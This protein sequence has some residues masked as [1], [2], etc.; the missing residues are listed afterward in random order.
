MSADTRRTRAG[1]TR[2]LLLRTAERLYAER[3][4]AAVSLRQ[5]V[6]AAGVGNNS[7]LAYHF[8]A[9]PDVVHAIGEV[10]APGIAAHAR[11]LVAA[12]RD[13]GD[14]REHVACLVLPYVRHLA[15][16]GVPSW[17]ARFTAQVA[18]DPSFG[19]GL[20]SHA[21]LA[22]VLEVASTRVWAHMPRLSPA[23]IT[24]RTSMLRQ[25]LIH[26][27]AQQEALAAAGTPVDWDRVGSALTD[28]ATGL[29]LASRA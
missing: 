4:L 13:A 6:E 22:P 2:A 19:D 15:G 10:H 3:G 8:G 1:D 20:H 16:L 24:L 27:C 14:P 5:I 29:V 18:A 26:T 12:S 23:E 28:A 25:G 21:E 7:A 9:R 11:T 17:F